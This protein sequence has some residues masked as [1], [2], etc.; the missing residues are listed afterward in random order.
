MTNK[1]YANESDSEVEIVFVFVSLNA[2]IQSDNRSTFVE[3]K[4]LSFLSFCF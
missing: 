4:A 3:R 2:H 1:S